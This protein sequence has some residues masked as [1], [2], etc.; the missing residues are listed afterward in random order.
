MSRHSLLVLTVATSVLVS[1]A[2]HSAELARPL[3]TLPAEAASVTDYYRQNVHDTAGQKIG[4]IV[5]ILIEKQGQV[6]ATMISVR[7]FLALTREVVAIPFTELHVP[8][9]RPRAPRDRPQFRTESDRPDQA[10]LR[11][12]MISQRSMQTIQ[13]T[14]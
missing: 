11:I 7:S 1:T 8:F 10:S 3:G 12:Q 6:P 5:D 14:I 2:G 4:E 9:V 13:W